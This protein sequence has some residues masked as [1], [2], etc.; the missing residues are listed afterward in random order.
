M[1]KDI[2][3]LWPSLT[4]IG[5]PTEI[6]P[7]QILQEQAAAIGE[8]TYN[9]IEGQVITEKTY[10]NN[11][12]PTTGL[13]SILSPNE[14][15]PLSNRTDIFP[16]SNDYIRHSLFLRTPIISG[17]KYRVLS[18]IHKVTDLYPAKIQSE[19]NGV[20]VVD[21]TSSSSEDLKI[22]LQE[23]L[24]SK[25]VMS[26]LSSLLAQSGYRKAA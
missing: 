22:L 4:E 25:E 9:I 12:I 7:I 14:I 26:V 10:Y 20:K 13:E 15:L 24:H 5:L 1:N 19:I 23:T 11:M 18:I 17:Y 21:K 8:G 3:S 16:E 2:K 6:A